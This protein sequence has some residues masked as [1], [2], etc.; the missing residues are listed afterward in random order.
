L[1][2]KGLLLK[3]STVVEATLIEAPSS[4]MKQS[5][6]REPDMH[7]TKNGNQWHLGMEAHIG[8]APELGLLH[9][10]RRTGANV[11]DVV[12]ANSL[13]HGYECGAF[14]KAGYQGAAS[15]PLPRMT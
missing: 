13:L 4:T 9:T 14:H 2:N 7:Q 8:L 3:A 1:P 15:G 6:D 5:G 10:V 12:Q 11:N